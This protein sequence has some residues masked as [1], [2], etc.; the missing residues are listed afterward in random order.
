VVKAYL[1]AI[2]AHDWRKVWQ[3]GGKNLGT[4]YTSMVTGFRYTSHDKLISL[5][6]AGDSVSA[7]IRAYETTGAVQTYT[8][9]YTVRD[10]VITSGQS[11]LTTKNP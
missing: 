5:T 6:T 3:L 1:A 4:T 2:N 10:G 9:S 11:L 7:L 8:L